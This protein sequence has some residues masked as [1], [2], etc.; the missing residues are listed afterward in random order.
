MIFRY[1]VQCFVPGFLINKHINKILPYVLVLVIPDYLIIHLS[2]WSYIYCENMAR[3]IYAARPLRDHISL[4]VN[5]NF[6]VRY[7][8]LRGLPSGMLLRKV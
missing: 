6:G 1:I 8:D 7:S 5:A 3:E 4:N 2:L